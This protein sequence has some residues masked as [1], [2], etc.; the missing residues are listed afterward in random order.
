MSLTVTWLGQSGLLLE[1]DGR[2][3]LIDPWLSSH[4]ER[5]RPPARPEHW[6]DVIDT[7]LITH[8]HGDHLDLPGLVSL[9]AE[10]RLGEIVAPVPHLALIAEYLPGIP[11]VG[12]QPNTVLDRSR[13][14]HVFPAWHGITIGDGY[15]PALAAD[16]SSPHVGFGFELERTR[17]YVS[18][19][20]LADPALI[21]PVRTF[22]PSIAFLPVNGRD[23]ERE[24]RGILGNMSP[25]EAAAFCVAI[26]ASTLMPLHHDGVTGN[27]C[28]PGDIACAIDNQPVHL[29]MP[30]R[31]RPFSFGGSRR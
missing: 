8:G 21:A 18:G 20:T 24:A 12:V 28:E 26:G 29:L 15:G 19:D 13:R 11:R 1:G 16:G 5:A 27:T 31:A 23:P 25:T 6:P 22:G 7:V 4:P 3:I 9:A 10:T 14:L 2:A 30:A 17:L